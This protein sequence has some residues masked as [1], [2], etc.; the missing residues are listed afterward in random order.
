MPHLPAVRRRKKDTEEH[1]LEHALTLFTEKGEIIKATR[2]IRPMVVP[3]FQ[4]G[5]TSLEGFQVHHGATVSL[6]MVR[7]SRPGFDF[8]EVLVFP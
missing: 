3:R 7:A 6:V 1:L 8:W 2:C 4:R 5:P